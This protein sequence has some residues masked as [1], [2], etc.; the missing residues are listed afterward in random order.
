MDLR[1][2][3]LWQNANYLLFNN[4]DKGQ[5]RN[6]CKTWD[7]MKVELILIFC[8]FPLKTPHVLRFFWIILPAHFLLDTAYLFCRDASQYVAASGVLLKDELA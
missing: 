3:M 5:I 6:L 4:S 1:F 8:H 7:S 2:R